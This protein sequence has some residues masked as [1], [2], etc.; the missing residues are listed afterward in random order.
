MRAEEWS[1]VG[2][3]CVLIP[4][5][6][7]AA[8]K[9]PRRTS[10]RAKATRRVSSAMVLMGIGTLCDLLPRLLGWPF[11]AR[12]A[13]ST[14]ALLLAAGMAVLLALNLLDFVR[15]ARGRPG[16]VQPDG[17]TAVQYSNDTDE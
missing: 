7:M 6:I 10:C 8:F 3:W 5:G 1:L 2:L 12:M 16:A 15:P 14:V 11:G 4:V 13:L 17:S 9:P